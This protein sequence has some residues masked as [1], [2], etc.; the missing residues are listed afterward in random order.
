M[1]GTRIAVCKAQGGCPTCPLGPSPLLIAVLALLLQVRACALHLAAAK[2]YI[3]ELNT[4]SQILMVSGGGG[5]GGGGGGG[6]G[7]RTVECLRGRLLAERV[8]SKAAKEEADQLSK[9]L[10]ELEKKLA[11]EV[12]VRNK[13]ERRLRR[14]IKKLESLKI[15]DVGLSDG[16]IGSLSSNGRSGYQAPEVE[17]ETVEE[18]NSPGS[19]TTDGSVPSGPCGDADADRDIA[20]ESSEGSCT[21]VNSSSQD[22]S[23]CSVVSEQSRAGSCMYLAGNTTHCSSEGSGGDHDSERQHLDASSGCGSAKSEEA[24]YESDDRLAL[25]LVDPQLVAAAAA[26]ADDDGPRTQDNETQ[27]GEVRARSHDEEQQEEEETNK[28][29]IVLADPQPQPAAVAAQTG[30]PKPHGDVESVL[31]ALRRV[32]EQLRYTIERRS[33]L[34]AYQE[35]YGH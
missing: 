32:K 16:S 27:A 6:G 9:R 33:Q 31:L 11:D 25:V 8:A 10:D 35:L 30:P 29:A 17:V 13:A 20:R 19:L 7:M 5:D 12:K 3:F 34:V 23:W 28:L 4:Q 21:Q 15:L 1:T 26:A 14:A 22:G 2:E 24:F 18:R